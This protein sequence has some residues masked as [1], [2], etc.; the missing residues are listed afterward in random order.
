PGA[1]NAVG[2]LIEARFAGSSVLHITGMTATKYMDREVGTVH[3]PL[4]Q[5]GM[6]RSVCKSAYRVRSAQQAL[7]VL[8][9]AAMEA[10]TAPAGP[11]SVEIPIDL[12]REKIERPAMLDGFVLP[13][14][15]PRLPTDP[16]M[17]ELAARV[18]QAKR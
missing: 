4:D 16:E 5:L 17:D 9:R 1:A 12:Q 11:V 7:G 10:L 14:P 8:T 3:D 6:L 15:P 13:L 2:G 18:L